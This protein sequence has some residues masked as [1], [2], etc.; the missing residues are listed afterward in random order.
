VLFSQKTFTKTKIS[1]YK[2]PDLYLECGS[3]SLFG[4]TD[5]D[6]YSEYGSGSAF[7]K[8]AGSGSA[9]S[10]CGFEAL[11]VLTVSVVIEKNIQRL[12]I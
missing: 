5:P 12:S 8:K 2:I 10:E 9:Y 7:N 6:P 4:N 11:L 3:R 1:Y